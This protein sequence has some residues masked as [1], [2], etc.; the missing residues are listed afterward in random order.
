[1]LDNRHDLDLSE[2][3]EQLVELLLIGAVQN[4]ITPEYENSSSQ[5]GQN[6]K[7]LKPN[8]PVPQ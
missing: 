3:L 6:F 7:R 1:M 8:D 2:V 4:Q 5:N